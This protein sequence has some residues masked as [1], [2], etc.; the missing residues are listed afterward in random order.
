MSTTPRG[1]L[2]PGTLTEDYNIPTICKQKFV[3]DTQSYNALHSASVVSPNGGLVSWTYADGGTDIVD[4]IPKLEY[5]VAI[6]QINFIGTV[7]TDL[8]IFV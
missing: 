8:Q 4:M 7:V 6:M 1:L 2:L 3:L 5:K